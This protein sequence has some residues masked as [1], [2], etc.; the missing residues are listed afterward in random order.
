MIDLLPKVFVNSILLNSRG[1]KETLVKIFYSYNIDENNKW[2]ENA[3]FLPF[4][5]LNI[6]QI[7]NDDGSDYSFLM[8][9]G[10][11]ADEGL[12]NTKVVVKKLEED[13]RT[14]SRSRSINPG[15]G[16]QEY[17]YSVDSTITGDIEDLLYIF[18]VSIDIESFMKSYNFNL[19]SESYRT[20]FKD[21]SKGTPIIEEVVSSRNVVSES[22]VFTLEE[23]G[24]QWLGDV[25]A[26]NNQIG[27]RN[28]LVYKTGVEE[29]TKSREL[30]LNKYPNYKIQ[31]F[32]VRPEASKEKDPFSIPDIQ[33]EN[34]KKWKAVN[35]ESNYVSDLLLSTEKDGSS[36]FMFSVDLRKL[37]LE[38]SLYPILYEKDLSLFKTFKMNS[39]VMK[40]RRISKDSMKFFDQEEP[41]IVGTMFLQKAILKNK[42]EN[43]INERFYHESSNKEWLYTN[44][45]NEFVGA[46]TEDGFL[47]EIDAFDGE[48]EGAIRHFCG[49]DKTIKDTTD[50]LFG[51]SVE[52]KIEDSSNRTMKVFA[53]TLNDD[54]M[55]LKK[56]LNSLTIPGFF[57]YKLKKASDEFLD[58]INSEFKTTLM[59]VKSDYFRISSILGILNQ[60]EVNLE[61][62][63]YPENVSLDSLNHVISLFGLLI[64]RIG[65]MISFSGSAI[66]KDIAIQKDFREIF[67]SN[68][69]KMSGF[70]ILPEFSN[71][72]VRSL[73]FDNFEKRANVETLK[74][75]RSSDEKFEIKNDLG[76]YSSNDSVKNTYLSYF[77]PQKIMFGDGREQNMSSFGNPLLISEKSNSVLNEIINFNNRASSNSARAFSSSEDF[78]KIPEDQKSLFFQLENLI[79]SRGISIITDVLNDSI[80]ISMNERIKISKSL[81]EMTNKN[82]FSRNSENNSKIFDANLRTNVFQ[83]IYQQSQESGVKSLPNQIKAIGLSSLADETSKVKMK[84]FEDAGNGTEIDSPDMFASLYLN[85]IN[86]FRAEMI[87][88]MKNANNP[89]WSAINLENL[90]RIAANSNNSYVICRFSRFKHPAIDFD[91]KGVEYPLLDQYFLIDIEKISLPSDEA[92]VGNEELKERDSSNPADFIRKKKIA[93]IVR[94]NESTNEKKL[95]EE[96]VLRQIPEPIVK[97]I[98]FKIPPMKAMTPIFEKEVSELDVPRSKIDSDDLKSKILLTT[99]PII[100]KDGGTRQFTTDLIRENVTL[101][102]KKV[103]IAKKSGI[104]SSKTIENIEIKGMELL[105]K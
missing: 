5:N 79:E 50:G 56:Y 26:V 70:M 87:I 68:K 10:M 103:G 25:H 15:S 77:S 66:N 27:R 92:I 40:R 64:S 28:I 8:Q 95:S 82:I 39:L 74:F 101:R 29:T 19:D 72:I 46:E 9:N 7:L 90:K 49:R 18:Q 91:A 16:V 60:D 1:E 36:N 47:T 3:D 41:V 94:V 13:G 22:F 61:S 100:S 98:E 34:I 81:L 24:E 93:P 58:L 59:Q 96:D 6:F 53:E 11:K 104:F 14:I 51:Y 44:E 75:F 71:G 54:L 32:R 97:E 57:D 55:F 52:I 102:V 65:R 23:S 37:L 84:W 38:N 17:Q 76:T 12:P 62:M 80:D 2:Y 35:T 73:T 83:K 85:F 88:S 42:D 31:D 4:L 99:P 48:D 67:D 30:V 45:L 105:T 86:I 89:E 69:Q 21:M 63:L 78:Q 20:L 33:S 43:R